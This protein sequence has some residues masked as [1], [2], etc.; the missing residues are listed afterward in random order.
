MKD[1]YGFMC[2]EEASQFSCAEDI[3]DVFNNIVARYLLVERS[4]HLET[5]LYDVYFDNAKLPKGQGEAAKSYVIMH[6]GK[7]AYNNHSKIINYFESVKSYIVYAI[8]GERKE[9]LIITDA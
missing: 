6:K 1:L 3:S 2:S 7:E 5:S 8:S 9:E 4:E